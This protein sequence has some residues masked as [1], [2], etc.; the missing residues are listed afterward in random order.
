MKRRL[1]VESTTTLG[2]NLMKKKI[3]RTLHLKFFITNY[4][5]PFP[6]MLV[7]KQIWKMQK[8]KGRGKGGLCCCRG[9]CLHY[10]KGKWVVTHG[11]DVRCMDA[12]SRY[13]DE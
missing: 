3:G 2:P 9:G 7:A 1:G 11:P 5:F 6:Y 13:C 8:V 12:Q 4:H 10:R